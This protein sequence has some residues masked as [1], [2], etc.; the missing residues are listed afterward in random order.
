MA[1]VPPRT[2]RRRARPGSV[3]RPVNG[4]L[5]RGTWLL[6]GLPL[7]MAAFSVARPTPLPRAFLPAFDG[8]ATKQIADDLV[9]NRDPNRAPGR[10][11]AAD[12]FRDQLAPYGLPV[13][14]ERFS[15]VIPGRGRV[16]L[17]NL[18]AEAV[19][20]APGTIVVM[21]HRDDTGT[22]PGANDN[23]SGTAML[24]QLARAYGSPVGVTSGRL[25]PNHTIL[26]LSTDGGAFGGL[27]AAWFAAHSPGRHDVAAVINLDAVGGTGP[28]RLQF[29]GDTPRTPSGTFLETVSA[30][31]AAQIGKRPDRPSA[32]DQLIDLGFPYSLYE[33]APFLA[34]GIAAVTITTGKD[35]PPDP[36]TDTFGGL[37]AARLGQVGRAAQDAI[38]TLD[39]G[40][41]FAQGTSSYVYFGSRLVRGWA[42]ELVL[43]ACLLPFLATA[44]DLFA[45]CR[46]RRIPLAPA[47]RAYRSRLGFWAWAVGLF[48]LFALVG[49]WP[50]GAARPITPYSAVAHD[51]PARGLLG[52]GILVLIGWF[53]TRERLLPRR[54]VTAEE[55]LAGHT[56]SL[57]CLAG[58]SLLVVGTNPFA[59]LF[60]L[61]TLHVW[62]WLPQ[63]RDAPLA[64]RLGVLVLGLAGPA[65]LVGSF[66]ARFGLGWD[67][68]WYLAELRA[69]D[70]VPFV[71]MPLLVIWLAATGQLAAL[72]TRRYAPYPAAEEL[73]PRGPLRRVLRA[74]VIGV[75][76]RRGRASG[77]ALEALD[78]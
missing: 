27:G 36:L 65:V 58:L 6:V 31:V 26:F 61:P 28:V 46:R 13:R 71:V 42:V 50:A 4:R 64:A 9:R 51:W 75:R 66:A 10:L 76:A 3:L 20:P 56:V 67:A 45:R 40:L 23:A 60:L 7:L 59:L 55:E 39:E 47:L 5:Y 52:L 78:G 54:D 32:L 17:Q 34:K 15:A 44:I 62:L 24:V 57:L 53:V 22:G 68:F 73:P 49:V 19:G 70:Y 21:A 25:H 30:R 35:K 74:A 43:I 72:A 1:T 8:Q 41:E 14:T 18:V 2:E 29:N 48:E 37:S 63:L 77:G 12:W 16:E 11:G 69:I 38:G 33:Q